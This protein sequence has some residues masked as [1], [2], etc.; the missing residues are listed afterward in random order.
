[1]IIKWPWL[2]GMKSNI[3]LKN[4]NVDNCKIDFI[5]STPPINECSQLQ[6]I[7]MLFFALMLNYLT[8]IS[9]WCTLP[10]QEQSI[11]T[12]L[13]L[14]IRVPLS[15]LSWNTNRKRKNKFLL[16][17]YL[18]FQCG[19][20]EVICTH[21]FLPHD[22]IVYLHVG[23]IISTSAHIWSK[24]I[25]YIYAN[26]TLENVSILSQN[27]ILKTWMR[28]GWRFHLLLRVTLE[29]KIMFGRYF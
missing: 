22:K 24:Y 29:L 26:I 16:I 18:V 19:I 6:P 8:T 27:F 20:V 25:K 23:L 5:L 28:R 1:M 13:A 15:L 3:A 21:E 9:T 14:P 2:V 4:S 10:W 11:Y 12:S 7:T 17:C